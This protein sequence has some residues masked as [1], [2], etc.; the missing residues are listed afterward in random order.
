MF[1]TWC[2]AIFKMIC[3]IS[4]S[5]CGANLMDKLTI[6]S[7]WVTWTL[8][9]YVECIWRCDYKFTG[10]QKEKKGRAIFFTGF[11]APSITLV[12]CTSLVSRFFTSLIELHRF[13]SIS[14]KKTP[15]EFLF[16]IHIY[17]HD[18]IKSFHFNYF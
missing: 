10:R 2:F 7:N 17:L 3:L 6:I 16:S 14:A 8:Y 11:S 12:L 18:R 1:Y 5:D 4:I 13:S 15:T 9:R